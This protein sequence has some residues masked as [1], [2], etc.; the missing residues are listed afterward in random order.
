[1]NED[2]DLSGRKSKRRKIQDERP[3]SRNV[4]GE[5]EEDPTSGDQVL[6]EVE[7]LEDAEE[8]EEAESVGQSD[9]EDSVQGTVNLRLGFVLID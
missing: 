5:E 7:V 9:D 4:E 1:M 8:A 3:T 2:H 6:D